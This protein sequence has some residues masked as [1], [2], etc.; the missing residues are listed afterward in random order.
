MVYVR[1]LGECAVRCSETSGCVDVSLSGGKPRNRLIAEPLNRTNI[2]TSCLLF[3][4]RFGTHFLQRRN[5]WGSPRIS[6]V[7]DCLP[8]CGFRTSDYCLGRCS[9]FDAA[10]MPS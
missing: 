6:A 8:K 2:C 7:R 5:Q 4:E 9:N 10:L 3:E 1:N